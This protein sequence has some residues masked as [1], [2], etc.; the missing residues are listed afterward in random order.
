MS[1]D[2]DWRPSWQGCGLFWESQSVRIK[3]QQFPNSHFDVSFSSNTSASVLQAINVG[4]Q[5]WSTTFT[6]SLVRQDPQHS[7]P[8]MRRL[9][10]PLI[11]CKI[12]I[13][14]VAQLEDCD[15]K[16]L[17]SKDIRLPPPMPPSDRLLAAVEAFYSPP[18]HDR[19]RNRYTHT[20]SYSLSLQIKK[21]VVMKKNETPPIFVKVFH[22]FELYLNPINHI[23]VSF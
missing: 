14:F 11:V 10:R 22:T 13:V 7:S 20:P 8:L 6:R 4:L 21:M 2:S 3:V 15:Y 9:H 19:P 17:D 18:S 23:N 1:A 12:T 16:A 5:L